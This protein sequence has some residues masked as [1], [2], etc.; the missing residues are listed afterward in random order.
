MPETIALSNTSV[1]F[2]LHAVLSEPQGTH[3]ELYVRASDIRGDV[4]WYKCVRN[5]RQALGAILPA[6][7]IAM[8]YYEASSLSSLPCNNDVHDDWDCD[9]SDSESDCSHD[10]DI[11]PM[12]FE[13]AMSDTVMHADDEH[14]SHPGQADTHDSAA[15]ARVVCLHVLLL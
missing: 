7:P 2:A 3:P 6:L 9:A 14:D 10:S 5:S 11:P 15:G 12:P 13:R 8:V 4:C 1:P